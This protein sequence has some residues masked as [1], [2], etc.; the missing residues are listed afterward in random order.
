LLENE[1]PV[2]NRFCPVAVSKDWK[3]SGDG[4]S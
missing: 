4:G 2:K 3:L 1:I